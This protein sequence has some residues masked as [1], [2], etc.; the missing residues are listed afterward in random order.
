[1]S[2][3]TSPLPEIPLIDKPAGMTSFD[4]IRSLRKQTG[5]KKFGHAGTLD[6]AAT[7]L[8][9]VGAG[10]GT[11]RLAD[12]IKLD[13]EYE[14]RVFIGVA[15]TTS[16]R[17]GEVVQ[18]KS[19]ALTTELKKQIVEAINS[20]VGETELPVSAY[21]AIKRDGVPMYERARAAAARGEQI[22]ELPVRLMHVYKAEIITLAES[23]F[24]NTNGLT[25]SV[26]FSVGSGT[27]IRS[28]AEEIGRQLGVPAMLL[29][30]RRTKVGEFCIEDALPLSSIK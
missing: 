26:R 15:T 2:T 23:T 4:V 28:L 11:R 3:H 1:M 8:L 7:G 5:L 9:V 30:L 21:S 17:D 10:P 14:A 27:Y 18:S 13:K 24:R 20:L 22:T 29:E 19:V 6:P 16:D 25:V 12:L